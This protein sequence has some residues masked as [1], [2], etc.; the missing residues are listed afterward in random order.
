[1][2]TNDQTAYKYARDQVTEAISLLQDAENAIEELDNEEFFD[3]K[4]WPINLIIDEMEGVNYALDELIAQ[5]VTEDDQ[6]EESEDENPFQ[7]SFVED[8]E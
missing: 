1:M 8:E 2:D 5:E 4:S 6:A 7:L 3:K